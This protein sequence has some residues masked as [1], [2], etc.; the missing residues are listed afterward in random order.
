[1]A[2]ISIVKVCERKC[3]VK[4]EIYIFPGANEQNCEKNNKKQKK[5]L[6]F[7]RDRDFPF[8]FRDKIISKLG[9]LDTPIS[10]MQ[11]II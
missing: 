11:L 3:V 6:R 7:S 8:C 1:M 10:I 4:K 5:P 2:K 9:T